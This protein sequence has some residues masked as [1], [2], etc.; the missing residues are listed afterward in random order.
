MAHFWKPEDRIVWRGIYRNQVWHAQ[1]VIVLNDNPTETVVALLPGTECIAPQG[2]LKGK[3][4]AQRRWDHKDSPWKLEKFHWQTNRL[5]F[6]IEPQKY[7]STIL[8]WHNESNEFLCYYINFQVPFQ[9]SHCGIDTLDLDLDLVIYP[10]F[11]YEWKDVDEYQK[12]IQCEI[13][14]PEWI[15]GI[16]EARPQVLNT[17]ETRQYPFDGSWLDWRPDPSWGSPTLPENW[18][19]I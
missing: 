6:L 12:A 9:R 15:K 7:Y 19:K 13:I 11:R 10:D 3:T 17:L 14:F 4:Y 2:Y 18:D 8:F 5:L 16:E 1:T